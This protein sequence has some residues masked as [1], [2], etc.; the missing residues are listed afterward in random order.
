M[1][2]TL[3]ITE[4]EKKSIL[5]IHIENGYNT[6]NET[7]NFGIPLYIIGATEFAK[8][9]TEVFTEKEMTQSQLSI[10]S[11][12]ICEK[13]KRFGS[14]DPKDWEG[15]DE[16]NVDN[17]MTINYPDSTLHNPKSPSFGKS[18]FTYDEQPSEIKEILLFLGGFTVT[19]SGSSWKVTDM[20][21]F[22]NIQ[23]AHPQLKEKG[24]FN[25]TVNILSGVLKTGFD[26][27]RGKSP[28]AGVEELLS[29][30][31]NFGYKGFP[32]E[33]LVP[34]KNCPCKKVYSTKK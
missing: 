8:K 21:N 1:K 23:K 9:R 13:S 5:K 19:D 27:Y 28:A 17:K 18:S 3:L 31:H 30:Y 34:K 15:K 22:D 32:V 26:L 25:T 11:N 2:K 6:I 29:Q 4:N 33:I 7:L 16:R 20:Y 14:C 10:L 24:W 12:I